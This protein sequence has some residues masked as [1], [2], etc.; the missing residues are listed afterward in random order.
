MHTDGPLDLDLG[1]ETRHSKKAAI[2]G[3]QACALEKA[4]KVPPSAPPKWDPAGR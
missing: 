2:G 1:Y 3:P 4:S